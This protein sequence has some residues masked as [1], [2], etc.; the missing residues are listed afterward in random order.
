MI[1]RPETKKIMDIHIPQNKLYGASIYIY[2]FLRQ[3][4]ATFTE[5]NTAP[6]N[7]FLL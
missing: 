1:T 6:W 2:I 3:L 7:S 4:G 5:C